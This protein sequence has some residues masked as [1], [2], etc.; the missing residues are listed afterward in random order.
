MIA[1]LVLLVACVCASVVAS[2]DY[3]LLAYV[4]EY[5]FQIDFEALGRVATHIAL[6]SIDCNE[7]GRLT[8]LDRVPSSVIRRVRKAAPNSKVL[9]TLG[10]GGRGAGERGCADV[11]PRA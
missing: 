1:S 8:E 2:T 7:R 9:V 4:P 6:F 3:E 5:R 11:V 10:G